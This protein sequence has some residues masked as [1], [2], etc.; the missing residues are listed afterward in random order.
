MAHH[1]LKID[2]EYFDGV[3][4]GGK[5]F[6]LRYNDRDFKAGDSV[7]LHEY[8]RGQYTGETSDHI[9]QYVLSGHRGLEPGWCVFAMVMLD[10][11]AT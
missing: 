9:I 11:S 1:D 4:S 6:E 2:P 3:I 8:R 7:T 10:R 5:N